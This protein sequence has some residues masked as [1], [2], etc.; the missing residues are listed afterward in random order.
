[1]NKQHLLIHDDALS[2]MSPAANP[3][4]AG[5]PGVEGR[6]GQTAVGRPNW[7]AP[8]VT[9]CQ[10]TELTPYVLRASD[11]LTA[12]KRGFITDLEGTI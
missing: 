3:I 4:H 11:G 8:S 10:D 1:M 6:V 7:S 9:L 2:Y 12:V 5:C